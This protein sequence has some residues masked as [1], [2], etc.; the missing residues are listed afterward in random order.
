MALLVYAVYLNIYKLHFFTHYSGK[1]AL[2][3]FLTIDNILSTLFS[4]NFYKKGWNRL[5]L[6]K[7]PGHKGLMHYWL[8]Y[9]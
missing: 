2:V 9:L 6:Y 1:S 4:L 3:G 7:V 8:L 5:I